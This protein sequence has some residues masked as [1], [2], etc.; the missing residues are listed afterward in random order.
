MDDKAG[1]TA[2]YACAK[3]LSQLEHDLDVYF[4]GSCQ[5]EV[6]HRG[7]KMVLMILILISECN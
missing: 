6:G 7:A 1:I 4:V 3:E 5:E 2:M